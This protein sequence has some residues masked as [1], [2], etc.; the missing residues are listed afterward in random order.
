[1]IIRHHKRQARLRAA[2]KGTTLQDELNAIAR[3]N[4]HAAWGDFQA[5]L[6]LRGIVK[7]SGADGY[8]QRAAVEIAP[9]ISMAPNER[10]G[11][12]GTM[13]KGFLPFK[14]RHIRERNS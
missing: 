14:N 7:E 12:L 11:I 8:H 13:D 6:W 9:I 1:M 3:E 5:A 4:G 2:A 10:S